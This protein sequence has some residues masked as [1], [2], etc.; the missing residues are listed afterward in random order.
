MAAAAKTTPPGGGVSAAG[1]NAA[2]DAPS[3]GASGFGN[4]RKA[5]L[6]DAYGRYYQ[7]TRD[8]AEDRF[9]EFFGAAFLKAYEE[10][11][12]SLKLSEPP[13]PQNQWGAQ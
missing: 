12:A 6:W 2:L 7:A 13:P 9:Q 8:E 3:F 5:K 10:A 4:G 1:A 11:T